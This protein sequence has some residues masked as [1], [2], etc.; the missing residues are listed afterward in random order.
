[1]ALLQ[2]EECLRPGKVTDATFLSK[3][4]KALGKHKHFKSWETADT[5]MRR[6]NSMRSDTGQWFPLSAEPPLLC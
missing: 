4:D 3:L 1:M 6:R 2:D 5:Q